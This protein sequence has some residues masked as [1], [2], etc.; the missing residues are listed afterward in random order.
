[1]SSLRVRQVLSSLSTAQRTQL[2]KLLP[3]AAL[4][5]PAVET[6]RYPSALLGVLPKEQAYSILGLVA[7]ELLRL[8]VASITVDALLA[9]VVRWVPAFPE[10]SKTKVRSSKTTAPFLDCIRATRGQ[11]ETRIRTAAADGP[12]LFNAE[13]GAGRPVVGHP[14]M[15]NNTQV[16]EVKLTGQL[17][18]NWV[19]FL[20]QTFAYGALLP[21]VKDLYIVL[22]LQK[23]VWHIEISGWTGR[24][25]FLELLESAATYA[26]TTGT[27]AM[28]LAAVLVQTY[29]IGC[30]APKQKSLAGTI[31]AL[32]GGDYSKPYQIF[33]GG[34]TTSKMTITDDELALAASAVQ[35]TG[36]RVYVHSQY[37]INLCAKTDDWNLELLQKN[38]QYTAAM[39]G[40]GV[41]V[42]VG[43]S[44]DQP[45]PAA[46]ERMR[47]AITKVL[48]SATPTTPLLLE[49]P[50]GQGTE[51]LK[52][53]K[54][55]IEFVRS[56]DD[57]RLRICLDTCHVFACGHEPLGYL[58]AA[59]EDGLLK[60][61][62][63]NDS[64]EACGSCLDRH[65]YIGT[66]KIG[67]EKMAA[68]AEFCAGVGVP[69]V[70]E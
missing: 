12:L 26:M 22:P 4:P 41:V 50:A 5:V 66:G 29:S 45:V 13:L 6:E 8:P 36:A 57:P 46:L 52:D 32:G 7:E 9:A 62:H 70:I 47:A 17:K 27:E 25:A 58:R 14:D 28:L 38:L 55:F 54:E 59:A 61:V 2:K 49:T 53:Q 15:L 42:H 19:D 3:K 69:M 51:T 24:A 1:M 10:A 33:L 40:R 43:K 37:I 34:P 60:L 48:S 56:F 23:A 20:F 11:L 30:H 67:G 64:Q 65:A 18:S 39:G 35:K 68:L 21:A 31:A 44:T 63:F 16:F